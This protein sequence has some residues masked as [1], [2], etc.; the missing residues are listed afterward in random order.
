MKTIVNLTQ[1]KKD[2]VKAGNATLGFKDVIGDNILCTGVIIYEKTELNKDNVEETKIVS[3]IRNADGEFITSVSPTVKN[4]LEMIVESFSDEIL[5]DGVQV[6]VK[7]KKSNSN[8][9]FL[10]LDLV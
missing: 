1:D 9:D 7:S 4:S 8:R 10:Y 3:A 2:I 5:A 6:I